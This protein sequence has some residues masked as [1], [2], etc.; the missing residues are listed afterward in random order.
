MLT[1]THKGLSLTCI[2]SEALQNQQ[3]LQ[4][5]SYTHL[6][7]NGHLGRHYLHQ[8]DE[9]PIIVAKPRPKLPEW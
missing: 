1:S 6:I 5:D 7:V 2:Q 4:V 8:I 3:I 9:Y